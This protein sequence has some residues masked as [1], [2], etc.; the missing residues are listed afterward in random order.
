[1]IKSGRAVPID[2]VFG[3]FQL[4]SIEKQENEWI[5]RIG[6]HTLHESVIEEFYPQIKNDSNN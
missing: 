1:M 2:S 4:H 6:C 3:G 5:M